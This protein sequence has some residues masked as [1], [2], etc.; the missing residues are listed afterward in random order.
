LFRSTADHCDIATMFLNMSRRKGVGRGIQCAARFWLILLVIR[1]GAFRSVGVAAEKGD[2]SL[3]TRV[4]QVR[5]LS[6]EE[7]KRGYPVRLDA[8]VIYAD[9]DWNMLFVQD[10]TGAIFVDP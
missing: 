1:G 3:L 2:R 8:V 4:E 9:L 10:P 7:A 6:V 5:K